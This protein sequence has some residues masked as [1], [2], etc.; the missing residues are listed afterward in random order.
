LDDDSVSL[1]G[2]IGYGRMYEDYEKS[3]E[4]VTTLIQATLPGKYVFRTDLVTVAT[5]G[6]IQHKPFD[7]TVLLS[8]LHEY[9]PISRSTL[10]IGST[11]PVPIDTHLNFVRHYWTP[12]P[13]P[14]FLD[15]TDEEVLLLE[16][17]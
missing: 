4:S 10:S 15:T 14:T 5:G 9:G 11:V 12:P 7:E 17:E 13:Q 2:T 6:Q 1:F 8:T 16:A 3:I